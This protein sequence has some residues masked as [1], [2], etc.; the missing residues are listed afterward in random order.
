MTIYYVLGSA[1]FFAFFNTLFNSHKNWRLQ[2][3][4]TLSKFRQ[5]ARDK[6]EA[7]LLFLW[8]LWKLFSFPCSAV[9]SHPFCSASHR[10]ELCRLDLV[11]GLSWALCSFPGVGSDLLFE[12]SGCGGGWMGAEPSSSKQVLSGAPLIYSCSLFLLPLLR[13]VGGLSTCLKSNVIF[14]GLSSVFPSDWKK[15]L[16]AAGWQ[17]PF[18][19]GSPFDF[20]FLMV[21]TTMHWSNLG[22]VCNLAQTTA[23]LLSK[24]LKLDENPQPFLFCPCSL[25]CEPNQ[26][27]PNQANFTK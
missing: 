5:P 27:K 10:S 4:G 11:S 22:N 16:Y 19:V 17:I 14:S 8:V 21:L 24:I 15:M 3:L 20:A 12:L 23:Y 7:C 26:I 18:R 13:F 9:F 25:P 1:F 6:R 2:S